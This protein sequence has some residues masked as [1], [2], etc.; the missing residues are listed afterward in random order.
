MTL[1]EIRYR[2]WTETLEVTNAS[3][4]HKAREDDPDFD[5]TVFVAG[6]DG[7]QYGTRLEDW[8]ISIAT[9]SWSGSRYFY[10]MT[11]LGILDVAAGWNLLLSQYLPD[12]V[13]ARISDRVEQWRN[14][15]KSD[16][17]VEKLLTVYT[18]SFHLK[19]ECVVTLHDCY[20]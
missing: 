20:D 11:A 13:V 14:V 8:T 9:C 10:S 1:I 15:P 6:P 2:P 12:E 17:L 5:E 16:D 7:D 4:R 19:D 3:A 18:T